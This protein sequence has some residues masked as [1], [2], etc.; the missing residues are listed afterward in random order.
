MQ[1]RPRSQVCNSLR[2]TGE[3]CVST[4]ATKCLL[5]P[6]SPP[7]SQ[8]NSTMASHLRSPSLAS[9]SGRRRQKSEGRKGGIKAGCM[10]PS[11]SS[12]TPL[13]QRVHSG[14]LSREIAAP[15]KHT[16]ATVATVRPSPPA[17]L[18][19]HLSTSF[20]A[21]RPGPST[22]PSPTMLVTIAACFGTWPLAR[23]FRSATG[24]AAALSSLGRQ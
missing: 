4:T 17:A 3:A 5:T 9:C 16:V 11:P 8:F 24:L 15:D 23:F 20:C 22:P 2:G 10:V 1:D 21:V 19:P 13:L 14:R 7:R 6:L 12:L 18:F